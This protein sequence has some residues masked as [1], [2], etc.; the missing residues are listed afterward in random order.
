MKTIR[1]DTSRTTGLDPDIATSTIEVEDTPIGQGG[2][3]VAYRSERFDGRRVRPQVVKLLKD[4]GTGVAQ[5]GLDTIRGLQDRL[6]TENQR[7]AG[8]LLPKYPALQGVPLL[9]FEGAMHGAPVFGYSAYDLVKSGFHEFA[10]ILDDPPNKARA[11]LALAVQARMRIAA[12]LVEAFELLKSNIQFI[13]ADIKADALFVDTAGFHCAIIDFDSGALA[14]NTNDR[15]TTFGTRQDWLAPEIT[16]QL[17][18]AGNTS[19]IIKVDLLSDVWSVNVAIHYLLFGIHPLFFLSE[20]SPRSVD[21]YLK[22]YKWPA[23]DPSFPYF[24]KEHET[25]Y[26]RYMAYV[27]RSVP[28]KIMEKLA[29]TV[30]LGF[31]DP[32]RRTLYG[33]WANVLKTLNQPAI[34]SFKPDRT[35]V[36]DDRPVHLSWDATG[37]DRLEL[38]NV[39]DVTNRTSVDVR[40]VQDTTFEL[41][42]TPP[43]G[44]PLRQT[45]LISVDK[46]PPVIST[47]LAST[48]YL[49]NATPARLTWTVSRTAARVQIDNGVG[50]VTLQSAAGVL[51]K[52]DTTYTL[53]AT[54]YFGATATAQVQIRVSTVSPK[55]QYFAADHALLEQGAPVNLSWE[56]SSD[57]HEVSISG[58]GA[59]QGKGSRQVEQRQ[60]RVYVLTATSYFGYSAKQEV[61]VD[62]SSAQPIIH[63]FNASPRVLGEEGATTISWTTSGAE[64]VSLHPINRPLASSGSLEVQPGRE[65]R[66]TIR[67]ESWYGIVAERH[68]TITVI[69]RARVDRS[70]KAV[71]DHTLKAK[72]LTPTKWRG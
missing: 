41:I 62:V 24:R 61:R 46:S 29:H 57:A 15:P 36:E 38:T 51:P 9:S 17:D 5:R 49:S 2:F 7:L 60:N 27:A 8:Q 58:V 30:N 72:R 53:T 14:R 64:S 68:I 65:S 25:L 59:V 55:I 20:I 31:R 28:A 66:L 18:Q 19:R 13:H 71:V 32:N 45:V 12:E 11:F 47:F 23:A 22:Q 42:L 56:V 34:R 44:Q 69:R 6:R 52:K 16:S 21:A 4:N 70:R 37:Y 26:R 54:S 50:D 35:L 48:N 67:A 10:G 33:Q 1:I 43:Q 40:I 3:G 63:D 39:G